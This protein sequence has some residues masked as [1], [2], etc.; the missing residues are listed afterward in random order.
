METEVVEIQSYKLKY[1]GKNAKLT[2]IFLV[3]ALLSVITLSFYIP[4]MKARINKYLYNNTKFEGKNFEFEGT[5]AE[6]FGSYLKVFFT[7]AVLG[8]LYY[9]AT[10][11]EMEN[12]VLVF[13]YFILLF[14][15]PLIIHGSM[16]YRME[17]S[18]WNGVPFSYVGSRTEF[19]FN[20]VQWTFYSIITLGIYKFW[21]V[22]HLCKYLL[23][24]SRFGSMEVRFKGK[25]GE[26]FL[27]WL[28]GTLLSWMTL[29]VY[30][31]WYIKKLINFFVESTSLYKDGRE[32]KFKSNLKTIDVFKFSI[33]YLF[34]SVF[35]LGLCT[36]LVINMIFSAV[37]NNVELEGT[38]DL[39]AIAVAKKEEE[40]EYDFLYLKL[41]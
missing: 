5:G 10:F 1:S 4:W 25:V 38:V 9:L 17:S 14:L 15:I 33:L 29:G 21:M 35:T 19:I 23:D 34:V 16:R 39:R 11:I 41:I 32:I 37:L 28:S 31:F 27:I 40:E 12:F 26:Y 36:G 24:H 18:S 6:M 7:L 30:S 22:I 2:G 13:G 3:N 20:F 8:T